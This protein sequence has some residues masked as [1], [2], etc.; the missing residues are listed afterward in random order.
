[1]ASIDTEDYCAFYD[2]IEDSYYA[3]NSGLREFLDDVTTLDEE[4]GSDYYEDI[5]RA[6]SAV[7]LDKVQKLMKE[8][9][10]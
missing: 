10:K 2:H 6:I 5:D 9:N 3:N 1:M 7:I 4:T 8:A